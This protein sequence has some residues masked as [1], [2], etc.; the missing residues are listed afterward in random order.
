MFDRIIASGM[1]FII[2][3]LFEIQMIYFVST[4]GELVHG[5]I[6]LFAASQSVD[7]ISVYAHTGPD[8]ALRC[9]VILWHLSCSAR[10][11]SEH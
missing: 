7:C 11:Q 1:Y 4:R 5:I 9:I 8:C 3:P 6:V 2:S 10:Q